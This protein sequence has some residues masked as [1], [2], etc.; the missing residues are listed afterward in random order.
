MA[1]ANRVIGRAGYVSFKGTVVSGDYRKFDIDQKLDTVEKQAGSE[2]TKSVIPTWKS[3][4][5]KLTYAYPGT[6]GYQD[7]FLLGT[8][9]TLLWGPE[10]SVAGK[11][12]GSV[13][14]LITAISKPM[15]Y[16]D[17]IVRTVDFEFQGDMIFNEE[18]AT[19]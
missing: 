14:G 12:K 7:L 15:A 10:G 8:E 18:T 11:P 19:F 13:M 1:L 6:A 2:T 17:L 3:G 9:G 4:T 16:D 5:A